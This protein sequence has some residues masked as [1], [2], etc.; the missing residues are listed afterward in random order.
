MT[1]FAGPPPSDPSLF[2]LARA[3]ERLDDVRGDVRDAAA[4]RAAV[5]RARPEIVLHLAAQALV[6]RSLAEPAATWAVNVQGTGAVLEAV[7]DAA[8]EAA[9]V[10]VTSDKCYAETAAPT[11]LARG[12]SA[13]RRDPYSASKAAQE[14]LA[15]SLPRDLRPAHRHRAGRQRDRRRRLGARP[16]RARLGPRGRRRSGA[17]RPQP[18]VRA[19]VAA[20]AQPAQSGYLLLAER[21]AASPEWARACNLG[22]DADDE[23]PVAWLVERLSEAWPA[24]P[25]IPPRR[26]SRR[27]RGARAAPGLRARAPSGS[28]GPPRGTWPPAC[29]PRP[30]GTPRWAQARM[31][32]RSASGSSRA[33]TPTDAVSRP[34]PGFYPCAVPCHWR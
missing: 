24:A 20:R 2:A 9:V 7:R 27:A 28:A 16:P 11:R 17:R 10:V 23:R 26:R 18:G 25:E 33:L 8:P 29:G 6:R 15:A 21:L 32:G 30:S 14:L 3:G 19:A 1:G 13:R 22:P 5:E 12:R 34:G 31:R 4:V